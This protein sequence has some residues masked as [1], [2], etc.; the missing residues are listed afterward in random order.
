MS[1]PAA[2]SRM[3]DLLTRFGVMGS[4][5]RRIAPAP[6]RDEIGRLRENR[7]EAERLR[8]RAF[9]EVAVRTR[10]PL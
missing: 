4:R 3:V 5:A 9:A 2:S 8:E 7:A 10:P 6:T 1:A